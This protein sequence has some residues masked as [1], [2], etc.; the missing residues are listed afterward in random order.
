MANKKGKIKA[1][2]Y[3]AVLDKELKIKDFQREYNALEEEFALSREVIHLR[4]E[5]RLSQAELAKKA[6][7]SQPAIARLE[8]GN[9]RNL[10]LSF[11]RRIAE[12]LDAT[13]DIHLRSK[14]GS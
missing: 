11:I 10:S 7:I 14:R 2:T 4:L 12:A 8:S 13:P 5:R 6:G 9:Y 1:Y 3:D